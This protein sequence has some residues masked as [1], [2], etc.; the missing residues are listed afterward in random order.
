VIDVEPV[1]P[2]QFKR[3]NLPSVRT[4]YAV[5]DSP[6]ADLDEVD[7][8]TVNGTRFVRA[9]ENITVL[10]AEFLGVLAA[11]VVGATLLG[12]IVGAWLFHC[13]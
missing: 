3:F 9:S 13:S 12:G 7:F 2:P 1:T 5:L 8:L 4:T 10:G 11:I 6:G